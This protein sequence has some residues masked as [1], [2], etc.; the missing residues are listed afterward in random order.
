MLRKLVDA[1]GKAMFDA[2]GMQSHMH[3]G[4][5]SEHRTWET[6]EHFV[7]FGVP[8]HFTE[9]TIV[10]GRKSGGRWEGSS[11]EGE[12]RQAEAVANFY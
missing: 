3:E 12:R 11:A 7:P 1:E 10:S 4:T 8:L 5:W 9:T 6:C 2:I